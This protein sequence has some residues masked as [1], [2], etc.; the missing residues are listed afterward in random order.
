[1][2]FNSNYF[3]N[4]DYNVKDI[5]S[6]I[7]KYNICFATSEKPMSEVIQQPKETILPVIK[8]EKT[9]HLNTEINKISEQN[10]F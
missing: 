8:V 5:E 10:N 7:D 4:L 6:L 2:D 1:M 3:L 9:S